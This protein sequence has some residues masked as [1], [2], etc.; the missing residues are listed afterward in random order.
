[1][2]YYDYC[3]IAR[4]YDQITPV[5]IIG[6]LKVSKHEFFKSMLL[7]QSSPIRQFVRSSN[8]EYITVTDTQ[9]DL[10]PSLNSRNLVTILGIVIAAI[11]S[12]VGNIPINS[13]VPM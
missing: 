12:Q 4:H 9:S 5:A 2:Y 1:M 10:S 3:V 6:C 13:N 8:A 11:Y 7:Q